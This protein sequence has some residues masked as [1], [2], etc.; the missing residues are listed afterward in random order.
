MAKFKLISSVAD[1]PGAA[2]SSKKTTASKHTKKSKR[3]K[4]FHGEWEQPF[5]LPLDRNL[6]AAVPIWLARIHA[7][8]AAFGGLP[9]LDGDSLWFNVWSVANLLE[10]TDTAEFGEI[11]PLRL[12]RLALAAMEARL[13]KMRSAE[14]KAELSQKIIDLE[15]TSVGRHSLEQ[16]VSRAEAVRTQI[17]QEIHFV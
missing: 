15:K 1:S 6:R 10:W 11:E 13:G 9:V 12:R 14:K 4:R 2:G 16:Y 3:N 8:F 5:S 7:D 17:E